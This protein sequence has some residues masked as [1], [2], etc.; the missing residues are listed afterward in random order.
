MK[1]EVHCFTALVHIPPPGTWP[2]PASPC[3]SS[4]PAAARS[5]PRWWLLQRARSA[6]HHQVRRGHALSPGGTGACGVLRSG[7]CICY[8]RHWR[9][10]EAA[11]LSTVL[12]GFWRSARTAKGGCN[13]IRKGHASW[14]AR[15]QHP[16]AIPTPSAPYRAAS[17]RT[18][19][20]V[21]GAPARPRRQPAGAAAGD[22]RACPTSAWPSST[23]SAGRRS[24]SRQHRSPNRYPITV[25][26]SIQGDV[27]PGPTSCLWMVQRA[28]WGGLLLGS[29]GS[30]AALG[31]LLDVSSGR[32]G[33]R[34]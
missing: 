18:S 13:P 21:H 12:A 24:L 29:C 10:D 15:A 26:L 30:W 31:R 34:E 33:K 5:H 16:R 4:L 25:P 9:T 14:I 7:P 2:A 8:T 22:I 3:G 17:T 1:G 11:P 32:D 27:D 19:R 23:T 28:F 6:C 20:V